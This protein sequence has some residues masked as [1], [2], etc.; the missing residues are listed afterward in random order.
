MCVLVS[1]LER[2][3]ELV[4]RRELRQ[5]I[6]QSDTFV[7]FDAGLNKAINKIRD[8][9]DDSAAS[10]RFIET[11]PKRGYRFIAPIEKIAPERRAPQTVELSGGKRAERSPAIAVLPFANMSA[12]K[13]DDYFSDGLSEEI[14]NA[15]T[16][17]PGLRVIAR[18]SSFR[19][20]GEQDLRKI[21][22]LLQVGMVL[23]DSVRKSGN[24]LRITAQ[25]IDV[26]DDSHIWSERY[27][28]EI[29]DVFAIQDEISTAIVDNLK[30]SFCRQPAVK[31]LIPKL[32]AY[33][34][35]LVGRYHWYKFTPAESAKALACFERAVAIDPEY[36]EAHV[37]IAHYYVQLAGLSLAEPGKVLAKG[38]AAA[39]RAVELD[40][41]LAHA[42]SSLGQVVLW[43]EHARSKAERHF[44]RALALAPTG[45]LVHMAYGALYLRA[46]ERLPEALAEIERAL[47]RDPLSPLFRSEQAVTL[48]Y[49]KRYDEAAESCR[50]ALEIDPNFLM[51]IDCLALVRCYQQRF[52]EALTLAGQGVEIHG[53]RSRRLA[54]LGLVQALAGHVGEAHRVLDELLELDSRDY[55]PAGRVA[56]IYVALGEKDMAFKWAHTAVEQRDPTILSVQ[57][58]PVFHPLRADSRYTALLHEMNLG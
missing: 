10:P 14:I 13:G 29:T 41:A 8:V 44:R 12:D 22:E 30:L 56:G 1:L 52:E 2:P 51:A 58:D 42:H 19:F 4:T 46:L 38:K 43:S 40:P 9:L 25:L 24:R 23:E 39:E 26:G 47:E 20:R 45:P 18:T 50:R 11:L 31:S 5:K 33:E 7:D 53:R 49:E 28:R 27:D 37:G 55:V 32:A 48:L 54:L 21:G 35:V 17:V 16:K 6:W 34:A 15:L 36:A 57:P 3:G